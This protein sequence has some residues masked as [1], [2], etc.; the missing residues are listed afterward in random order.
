MMNNHKYVYVGCRTTQKRHAIGKGI[1]IYEVTDDG[2]WNLID[3]VKDLENPSFIT[4][5]QTKEFLY[6]VHG[7]FGEISAFKRIGG[8]KLEKLNTLT[9]D[10][11]NPV[12]II[13]SA[14]N[15]YLI[16]P[17]LQTGNVVVIERNIKTGELL[18]VVSRQIVTGLRENTVSHPHQI[19]FDRR[20]QRILVPCQG[21]EAGISKLA[22]FDFDSETG[23]LKLT[24]ERQ[25]RLKAEA[26]HVVMHPNGCFLYLVSERD[27]TISFYRYDEATGVIIPIQILST[28]PETSTGDCWASGVAMTNDG[29]FI[30]VSNR[31]DNSITWYGVDQTTG[32]LTLLGNV[33]CL[34]AHPRFI[35]LGPTSH[36]LYIANKNTHTIYRYTRCEDGRLSDPKLMANTGSPTCLA[37]SW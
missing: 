34:G 20:A 6:A 7:D 30:Y 11:K 18:G 19:C 31:T 1:S 17:F 32:Y 37:F 9:L 28:L 36:H 12:H 27:S 4:L 2:S 25:T 26:R 8:G 35:T 10:A 24:F 13:V 29:R 15:R 5:D 16:V 22:V 21:R 33:S 23:K 3:I 14:N